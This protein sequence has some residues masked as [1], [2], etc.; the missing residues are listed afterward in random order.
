MTDALWFTGADVR[1]GLC[2]C[3]QSNVNFRQL[4]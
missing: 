4:R 2:H 3:V 1:P